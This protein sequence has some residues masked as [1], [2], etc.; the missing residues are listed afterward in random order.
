[1][2]GWPSPDMDI[3][4]GLRS[5]I[6]KKKKKGLSPNLRPI[7]SPVEGWLRDFTQYGIQVQSPQPYLRC[8]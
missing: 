3:H 7:G 5:C 4:V 2:M 1:M 8:D 6:I